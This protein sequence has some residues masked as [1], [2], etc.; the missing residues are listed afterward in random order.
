MGEVYL[1]KDDLINKQPG[2]LSLAGMPLGALANV[3]CN[4]LDIPGI[5]LS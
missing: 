1:S 5:G 3:V 2:I 4:D